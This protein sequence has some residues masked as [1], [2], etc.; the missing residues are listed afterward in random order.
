MSI[1]SGVC[2]EWR[3]TE[4]VWCSGV[5]LITLFIINVARLRPQCGAWDWMGLRW[6]W[7]GLDGTGWDCDGTAMGLD[8]TA[9]GLD[10]TGWDWMG[11]RW[12]WMGLRWDWMGLDGTAMGLRWDWIAGNGR[13]QSTDAY[14]MSVIIILIALVNQQS[15]HVLTCLQAKRRG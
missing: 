5:V 13:S 15:T 10:G 12:D 7:M 8:G 11:L 1:Y 3:C 4:A 6:D 9:M 2:V 14:C